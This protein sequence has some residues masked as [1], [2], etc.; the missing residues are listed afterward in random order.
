MAQEQI[1]NKNFAG[2][3]T[4][5]F[6]ALSAFQPAFGD[7]QTKDGVTENATMF[8]IKSNDLPA[9]LGNYDTDPNTAFNDGS[10]KTNRY[11][12]LKEIIYKEQDVPYDGNWAFREGLDRFTV[13][14]DLNSAVAE[15]LDLQ[16]QAKVRLFNTLFGKKL[17]ESASGDLGSVS[18]VVKLFGKASQTYTDMEIMTPVR[19][20][21]DPETYNAIVDAPATTTAKNSAT[22]IDTNGVVMLKGIRVTQVPTQYMNGAKVIFTPDNIGRAF[23]GIN[24]VRTIESTDFAGVELQGAGKYGVWVSDL[25]KKAILTAGMAKGSSASTGK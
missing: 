22:N 19:A 16:S 1:F 15:R 7:L 3:I 11:G 12:K 8:S 17:T 13:N 5:A 10:D 25:N 18:D 6:R 20:Y 24:I 9:E 2:I 4:P 21:V 23:L 14:A